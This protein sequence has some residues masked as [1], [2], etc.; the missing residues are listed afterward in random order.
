MELQIPDLAEKSLIYLSTCGRIESA[1]KEIQEWV[2]SHEDRF[3]FYRIPKSAKSVCRVDMDHFR[4]HEHLHL[5]VATE[6]FFEG[7]KLP[8]PSK[9]APDL[10]DV[11][12]PFVGVQ[13]KVTISG[14]FS[15]HSDEP[16][17]FGK[18]FGEL[19]FRSADIEMK[20][21]SITFN[22]KG[23]P[24]KQA[25][26]EIDEKGNKNKITTKGVTQITFSEKYLVDCCEFISSASNWF[27]RRE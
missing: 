1:S 3:L 26:W 17:R 4:N 6:E 8:P 9:D 19:E 12:A 13:I 18:K 5:D 14:E 7:E 24:I 2:T 25:S 27:T 16:I 11:L 22:I 15:F 21:T 20:A 23:L 10:G